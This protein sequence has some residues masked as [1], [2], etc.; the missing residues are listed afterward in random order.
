MD[1]YVRPVITGVGHICIRYAPMCMF[2]YM[3]VLLPYGI[4]G[5]DGPA[6]VACLERLEA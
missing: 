6:L 3:P 2:F 5:A 4:T 1:P